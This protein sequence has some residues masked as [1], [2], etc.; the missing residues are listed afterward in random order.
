M[1]S[2][3]TAL[4]N[5]IGNVGTSNVYPTLAHLLPYFSTFLIETQGR[6][7][8]MGVG[9]RQVIRGLLFAISAKEKRQYWV[10]AKPPHYFGFPIFA[11]ENKVQT[12]WIDPHSDF[13]F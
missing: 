8:F 9:S 13:S 4:H 5:S 1:H 12:E 6:A 3:V 2:T 11:E 7:V 10:Y